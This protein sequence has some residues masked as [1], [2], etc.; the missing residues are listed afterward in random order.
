M[1]KT[2]IYITIVL[3][4][5]ACAK[6]TA[7]DAAPERHA[8]TFTADASMTKTALADDWSV[9][10]CEGDAINIVWR[11]G[12]AQSTAVIEDG[13]ASFSAIVDEVSEYYAVYPA[14]VPAQV[15][16]EGKLT[17][18]LPQ[19]QDGTFASNAVIVA[20]TTREALDFGRFKSAV[21][22]IRFTVGD[23]SLTRARFSSA[24]G[25]PVCGTVSMDKY[26]DEFEPQASVQAVDV[27]LD[28]NGTYYLAILPGMELSGM[29]FQLGDE[30][31]W[32]GTSA[33]SSPL[34]PTA[35]EV[36]CI[37][38]PLEDHI[39]VIG[40][41]YI[42]V[43]GAG[44]KDGSSQS[45]A[46]DAALLRSLLSSP[47]SAGVLDGHT[48]HIAAGVYDLANGE[49]GIVMN[50]DSAATITLEGEEGTVFTTSL[51]EAQGCI[52][53]VENDN[54]NLKISSI[55]FM[56]ASHSGPG[57]ALCLK[58]GHH[59]IKDCTFNDNATTSTTNYESGGALYLGSGASADISG[60]TFISNTHTANGGGAITYRSTGALRIYG[61][62]FK[63][64]GNSSKG[65]G[66]AILMREA[67]T[68]F[69]ANSSFEGNTC[70][71]NGSDIFVS[72]G[73]AALIYNCTFVNPLNPD[74]TSAARGSVR[75]NTK[76]F[77][78]SCTVAM[79]VDEGKATTNGLVCCGAGDNTTNTLV[80]NLILSDYG[81]SVATGATNNNKRSV[82]S[83][84]HNVYLEA[85]KI[86]FNGSSAD[87]DLS[88][89]K[90]QD[91]LSQI[92]LS[93][94]GVLVWDGPDAK[95][96]GFTKASKADVET[97]MKAFA[98]GG[99]AF[100]NWLVDNGLFDKDGA[101]SSR[102]EDSWW[103][104]AYQA[105]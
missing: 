77:M 25:N 70:A 61:C 75:V 86:T 60:C 57:G 85:P 17:I 15:S 11:G 10:W 80:N 73:V 9:S 99:E 84:G 14:T 71:S 66:G 13:K 90:L 44:T 65:N 1:K 98:H 87:S 33:S 72:N 89:V 76:F 24:D 42:T 88:G 51:T 79:E 39:A 37:N 3:A 82:E 8:L 74:K 58:G 29:S 12:E 2:V 19:Q 7:R 78:G 43:E 100:F 94:D 101:G 53:T 91:I 63:G 50:F 35:G 46:G 40:D 62:L 56:G 36:L 26:L 4:A 64:N 32:K 102:G 52:L 5:V 23:Q 59:V 49:E 38:T 68:L 48:V 18:T 6:E 31:G 83:G 27:A 21:A 81:S 92:E 104:G 103:P 55:A 22:M 54:V 95:L 47:A 28:G 105:Q 69:L 16:Q 67:G 45:N 41:Y 34:W 96:T 30:N 20:H 97:S 93:E